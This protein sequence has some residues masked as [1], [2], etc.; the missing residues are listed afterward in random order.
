VTKQAEEAIFFSEK[1]IKETNEDIVPVLVAGLDFRFIYEISHSDIFKIFVLQE[2]NRRTEN[3]ENLRKVQKNLILIENLKLKIEVEYN[4]YFQ[5]FS[6][7]EN[8]WQNTIDQLARKY[9]SYVS[10]FK[11]KS[12]KIGDDLFFDGIAK[13]MYDWTQMEKKGIDNRQIKIVYES[14]VEPLKKHCHNFIED[15][16]AIALNP[17]VMYSH[18][19]KKD[20]DHKK[21]FYSK[22]FRE[23]AY[24][25]RNAYDEIESTIKFFE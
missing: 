10:V 9:D 11:A 15:E 19:I 5:V 20:I 14:I 7:L 12:L 25:M 18:D 13:I 8:S 4:N 1:I 21:K 3:I 24:K 2:K 6:S 17:F 22:H 23:T 16:R